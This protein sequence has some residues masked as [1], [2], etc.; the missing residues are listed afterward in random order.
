MVLERIREKRSNRGGENGG[1][2]ISLTYRT[3]TVM[4]DPF[5]LRIDSEIKKPH[6]QFPVI[7]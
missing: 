1:R 6:W 3:I 5:Y 7:S 4:N 2:T